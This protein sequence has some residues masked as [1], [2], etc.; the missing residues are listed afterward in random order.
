MVPTY[1]WCEYVGAYLVE[2]YC[3]ISP[4]GVVQIE[5]FRG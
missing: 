5:H 4:Y 1:S 3:S 2:G